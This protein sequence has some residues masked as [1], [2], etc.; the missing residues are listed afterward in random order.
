M[1]RI[2]KR[3][4]ILGS[5]SVIAAA[6]TAAPASAQSVSGDCGVHGSA[7]VSPAV[8]V[9]P[10]SGTYQFNDLVFACAG[11]IDGVADVARFDISTGGTYN[12]TQCGT[13]SASSTT[14]H[15]TVITSAAGNEGLQFDA[16]YDIAFT[17][18]VG[19]LT[20]RDGASGSGVV[21][22]IPTGPVVPPAGTNPQAWDC[23]TSFNVVGEVSLSI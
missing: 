10:N 16:P 5:L 17:D 1:K 21:D 12:N 11:T 15:G 7:T 23:T 9:G 6:V 3:L 20:F 8:K 19:L 4:V 13:G 22:I 18:G 14:A 2:A